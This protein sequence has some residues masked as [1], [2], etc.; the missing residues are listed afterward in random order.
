MCAVTAV[1]KWWEMSQQMGL[2][3]K[4]Y[5]FRKRASGDRVAHGAED[6]MVSHPYALKE[7]ALT[8][9]S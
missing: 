6:V 3:L 8:S 1:A 2:E 7:P 5:V 4:G 9:L